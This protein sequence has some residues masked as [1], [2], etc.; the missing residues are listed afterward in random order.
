MCTFV[1]TEEK[2]QIVSTFEAAK[3]SAIAMGMPSGPEMIATDNV[4]AD[5]GF[6]TEMF[7]HTLKAFPSSA[8]PASAGGT[9]TD[10]QRDPHPDIELARICRLMS[11]TAINDYVRAR[12]EQVEADAAARNHTS[13]IIASFDLEWGQKTGGP[14]GAS[15]YDLNDPQCRAAVLVLST[16]I[17]DEI[18]NALLYLFDKANLPTQL[19]DLLT[20]R[21]WYPSSPC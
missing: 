11:V 10:G 4:R 13:E 2:S 6:L 3:K 7:S 16:R 1:N 5:Q 15:A 20:S 18:E 12:R 19:V 21:R 14:P 8:T 17:G 9:P